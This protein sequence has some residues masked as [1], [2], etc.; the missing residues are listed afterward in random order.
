MSDCASNVMQYILYQDNFK[1]DTGSQYVY[2]ISY[3]HSL[4]MSTVLVNCTTN[5]QHAVIRFLVEMV[6]K[7]KF[8]LLPHSLYS[9]NFAP[10][11]Y[12]LIWTATKH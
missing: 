6:Q 1:H 12:H 4:N 11:D 2:W 5:E 7:L 10:C 3:S 9:L 8:Q